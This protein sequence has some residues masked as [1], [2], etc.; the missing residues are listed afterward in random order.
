MKAF[1]YRV[2]D[3]N[4]VINGR[5]RTGQLLRYTYVYRMIFFLYTT[6]FY[7]WKS[8]HFCI[9]ILLLNPSENN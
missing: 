1:A 4:I 5:I 3:H 2:I 7:N 6:H 9:M 8:L